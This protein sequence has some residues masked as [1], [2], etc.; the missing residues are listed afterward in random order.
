MS[1]IISDTQGAFV[2]GRL[3]SVNIFV[4]HEMVHSLRTRASVSKELWQLRLI[5]VKLMIAL[6]EIFWKL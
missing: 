5:C 4:A 6:N 2:A 3:P 1:V